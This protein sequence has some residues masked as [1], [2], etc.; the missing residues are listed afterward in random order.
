MTTYLSIDVDAEPLPDGWVP[1]PSSAHPSAVYYYNA[2]SRKSQWERPL[3]VPAPSIVRASHILVKH[4]NV[5]NKE[6]KGANPGPV[7][8]SMDEARDIVDAAHAEVLADPS[9][10][11]E[12]AKRMSDCESYKRG[13]D[14]GKFKK[15]K[16][17]PEVKRVYCCCLRLMR[18]PHCQFAE[19]AY[20]LQVGEISGVVS[21]ASGLHV[22]LRT[23]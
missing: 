10:F 20:A 18:A 13:G 5:R 16:M 19:A 4:D 6:S 21:S 12:V 7:T 8:R 17:H 15:E 11:A 2:K 23:E 9:Q 3:A 22:I 1:L 14:V